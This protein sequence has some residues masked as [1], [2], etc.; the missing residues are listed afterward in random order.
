MKYTVTKLSPTM[1]KV[2]VELDAKE[3]SPVKDATLKSATST[4]KIPG[5]RPGKIPAKVAEQHI[6]RATFDAQVAEAAV[7]KYY[8]PAMVESKARPLAQPKV[9]VTK[10]EPYKL[11]NF[12]IEVE[13]V[14]DITLPDYRK[15]RK[16]VPKVTVKQADVDEVIERLR[17][18][19]AEKEEVKRA[20]KDGDEVTIDFSGTDIA[21]APVSGASGTDYPLKLGSHTFI[22]GFEEALVGLKVGDQKEF[23]LTFPKDYG[24]AALAG[25]N[26]TFSVTV[27]KV[28]AMKLAD[29]NDEFAKKVGQ[30]KTIK[31]L[32]DDIK[33][34]LHDQREEEARNK[35]KSDLIEEIV[36][37]SKVPLPATL[38]S[39]Q[40]ATVRHDV[41]QNLTYRGQTL[42]D[43]LAQTKQTEDQWMQSEIH[44]QAEKR[45]VTGLV[46]AKLAK[47]EE[48]D[49]SQE[50]LAAEIETIKQRYTDP[51]MRAQL[52]TE[53]AKRQVL[54]QIVTTKTLNKLY[55]LATGA[56]QTKKPTTKT[57]KKK[58]PAKK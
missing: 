49:V 30:F 4:M 56:A 24:V 19:L 36:S 46:L 33:K 16:E 39:E 55:D 27:K 37:K 54:N 18:Q 12:T 32:K 34:E 25:Q 38:I 35:L 14:P 40:E 29:A 3:I 11:L 28:T 5:F 1:I 9:E 31:E 43:Y 10:F 2:A 50:E 48:I 23:T 52:D 53:D 22:P 6:N 26:V 51:Q 42:N 41:L 21:G 7:Q 17:T 8:T 58:S 57:A 44:G 15:I 45:V 20:A 13:V 47:D